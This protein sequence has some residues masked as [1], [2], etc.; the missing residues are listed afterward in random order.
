MD[1]EMDV[2]SHIFSFLILN[3]M[4]HKQMLNRIETIENDVKYGILED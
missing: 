3:S 1:L 4:A 2:I